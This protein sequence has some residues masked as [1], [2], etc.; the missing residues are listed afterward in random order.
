MIIALDYDRTYTKDRDLFEKF[1]NDAVS[2]GHKVFIVTKR[3]EHEKI[4]NT[5]IP[6]IYCN[7]KAKASVVNEKNIKIDIWIDD[8]PGSILGIT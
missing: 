6:I 8:D 3:Y 2:R 5:D 1:A 4:E 7:R